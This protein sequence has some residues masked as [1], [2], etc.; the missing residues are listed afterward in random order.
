[1]TTVSLSDLQTEIEAAWEARAEVSA[2]T[3]GPARGPRPTSSTPAMRRSGQ[4]I[5]AA[6]ELSGA[7][8][9]GLPTIALRHADWRGRI[10]LGRQGPVGREPQGHDGAFTKFACHGQ[11]AAMQFD[12]PAAER[13][14]KPGPA[15][16]AVQPLLG[17]DKRLGDHPQGIRRDADTGVGD[18]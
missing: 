13:Q 17:L 2:A 14:A 5:A 6:S 16:V 10:A 11:G 9:S 3:T 8:R 7:G 12:Q 18:R 4:P 1:M 15:M